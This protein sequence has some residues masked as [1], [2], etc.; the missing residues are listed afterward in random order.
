MTL[1]S[2]YRYQEILD[3]FSKLYKL[4]VIDVKPLQQDASFRSYIRIIT[5]KG[6]YL[7]MDCSLEVESF[8]LFLQI[9]KL[10]DINNIK[11]PKILL[12]D[13]INF[14]A[15][16][17]DLGSRKMKDLL[18]NQNI[19]KQYT[20][21]VSILNIMSNIQDI[22]P[23]GNLNIYGHTELLLGIKT[24]IRWYLPYKNIILNEHKENELIALCQ[25]AFSYLSQDDFVLNLLDFHVE[26]LMVFD[27]EIYVIDFQDARLTWPAYDL[28]SLLQDARY[29]IPAD[30]TDN[31]FHKYCNIKNINP[32]TMVSDYNIIGAQRNSRILG[33]F[34]RKHMKDNNDSYLGLIPLVLKYLRQN[35]NAIESLQ[36]IKLWMERGGVI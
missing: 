29:E 6:N 25:E 8:D 26:N 12:V 7:I 19:D 4:N 13:S 2:T 23:S 18:L 9:Q 5:D 30:I 3:N 22:K 35:L 20:S 14:L 33:V 16:I 1:F 31:L 32:I 11:T 10:L 21:Y 24:F 36:D 15:I 27:N 28:V 34:A 17:Q